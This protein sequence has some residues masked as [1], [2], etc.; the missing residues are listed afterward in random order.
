[1][2][3]DRSGTSE[4][5]VRQLGRGDLAFAATLHT[6]SLPNG[7]FPRLGEQFMRRY[8]QSFRR[9]PWAVALV[10]ESGGEPIGALVGTLDDRA[11]YR[12]VA[13]RCWLPLGV[14]GIIALVQRPAVA[15]WF[16]RS[17]GRRYARGL[18]RLAGWRQPSGTAGRAGTPVRREGVLT[19]VVVD[20]ASRGSGAGGELVV[21]FVASATRRGTDHLRLVTDAKDGAAAFYERLGWKLV[22]RRGDV[23]GGTWTELH[24]DL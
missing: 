2:A 21:E 19:H 6:R 11:H 7:F 17:R 14:A 3:T 15:W 22:G 18:V 8:Y 20:E 23:D 16:L 9:S 4:L 10:A 1:M 12:F 5:F 13:R 24:L